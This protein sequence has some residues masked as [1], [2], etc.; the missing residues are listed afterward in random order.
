MIQVNSLPLE[1]FA[2]LVVGNFWRFCPILFISINP[3]LLG[4]CG[5][6]EINKI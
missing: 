2:K 5:F 3:L 4:V 6:T 1:P